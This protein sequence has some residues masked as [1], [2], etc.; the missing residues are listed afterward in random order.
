MCYYSSTVSSQGLYLPTGTNGESLDFL[1]S[2]DNWPSSSSADHWL[3][4]DILLSN[5]EGINAV[6]MNDQKESVSL[7]QY[8]LMCSSFA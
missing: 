5:N 3:S 8:T 2:R 4:E 1:I 6:A 7:F